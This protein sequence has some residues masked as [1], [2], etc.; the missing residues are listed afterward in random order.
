MPTWITRFRATVA[1]L[2][3]LLTAIVFLN[4]L[5]E[6]NTDIKPEVYIAPGD[7]LGRYISAWQSS[8]YLGSPNFNVG[9]V[10]VLLVV[11][12]LRGIGLSPEWA[13]KVFHLGLWLLAAVGAARLLRH[14]AP[15]AGRWGGLAAG[16]LYLANPYTIQAGATLAIALPMALLPWQVLCL[17]RALQAPRSWR[18]PAAFG[19]TFF[20]MSGM[21]VAVVPLLQL[22]A[23]VPVVIAARV[24]AGLAW[25]DALRVVA[26]CALFVVGV[27]LYWLVPAVSARATGAQIVEASETLS[28]IA[29]VS[30]YPEVLRGVGLWPLYGQGGDET[31]WVPQ[32][33]VYV[34]SP[35][36]IALTILW[37]VLA[38]LSLRFARGPVRAALVGSI[39]LAAVIMVGL[40]PSESSPASPFGAL[41]RGLLQ[42]PAL[43]AFRTTNKIGAVLV[44]AF[45]LALGL[46]V[47]RV[48]PWLWRRPGAPP[49]VA[50]VLA[51]VLGAWTLPAIGGRLYISPMNIPSYWKEAARAADQG[52]PSSTT[53]LLPGQVRP[54]YRWTVERPDDLTNSLMRRDA[55]LPDTTPNASPPGVNF[56]SALDATVQ[57]GQ[58]PEATVSTFARYLGSDKVL[59][60]HDTAWEDDGGARPAVTSRL[61]A[62]DPGLFGAGNFGRLGQFMMPPDGSGPSY[63]ETALPPVQLYDV[64]DARTAARVVPTAGQLVV[65]G[66]GFAFPSMTE[67][68]LL[69]DTPAVRYAQDVSAQQLARSLPTTGRMVITDTNARRDAIPNRLTAGQGP[70]LPASEEL[71]QSRTLGT[72][73]SDQTVLAA[74]GARVTASSSGAA[75]FD[76][77]YGIPEL[78]VDGDPDTGWR[79]GDF[80][81]GVGQTLTV[82]F[83]EPVRLDTV[84]V[85]QLDLGGVSIDRVTLTAG[86]RSAS[87]RLPEAGK[88]A[89]LDLG[90]VRADR[91]TLRIDSLRGEGYSLVG[92]A[93]LGL[94]GPKPVRAAR[95]PTTFSERY[96]ALDARGKQQFGRTPLDVLLRRVANEPQPNDDSEAGLRRVVALPDARTYRTSADVR[97]DGPL[98][99][100]YDR[101]AGLD[102]SI[103]VQSSGFFFDNPD[104]RASQAA[105]GDNGT[106]WVPGNALRGGWWEI[107]GPQR[108]IDQVTINQVPLP[109]RSND[110]TQFAGRVRISVDGRAVQ[111]ATLRPGRSSVPLPEGTRGRTVRV[112]V[113]GVD[114]PSDG[115]PARFTEIDT[116]LRTRAASAADR[117]ADTRCQTVATV[118]GQP[119][120]MRPGRDTQL[121][122]TGQPGTA[123]IG[124][125]ELD[126]DPGTHR[127]D[128]VDG[129]VLDNLDL[130]DTVEGTAPADPPQVSITRDR[131]SVKTLEVAEGDGPYYVL[132]GT[133]IDPRWS[134]TLEDGTDLGPPVLVDGFS[135]GWLVPDGGAHTITLR[136]DP[137]RWSTVALVVSGA[138]VVLATLLTLM[139]WPRRRRSAAP[140][141][142]DATDTDTDAADATDVATGATA[143]SGPTGQTG[144]TGAT[145]ASAVDAPTG[146]DEG[147]EADSADESRGTSL[148]GRLAWRAWPRVAKEALL[149]LLATFAVGVPGLVAGLA[150]VLLLRRSVR[151]TRLLYAG[152]GLVLASIVVYLAGLGDALGKVSADAVASSMWPHYLAGGGLVLALVGALRLD[153]EP[154]A[155]DRDEAPDGAE[156]GD[157]VRPERHDQTDQTDQTDPSGTDPADVPQTRSADA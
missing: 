125:G 130:R 107:S 35:M 109:E 22:L 76:L 34:A 11:G 75:F 102:P 80:Q 17:V 104:V 40:F 90:G 105:D 23:I 79:F 48:L 152:A 3:L 65:A 51:V 72:D 8:P 88:S 15:R 24:R 100:M 36:I 39:A 96:A 108:D 124:C 19:L 114:G 84:P 73:P 145:A 99:P 21:N 139:V 115:T 16:V 20:L 97:V 134:A 54:D 98:E 143:A 153:R 56:L 149:V 133:S 135:A 27:S 103:R 118:D 46:A 57:S 142:D 69:R 89:E 112:T 85:S 94:P 83:P 52:N 120:R 113:L 157:G 144:P 74:S 106:A 132:A 9:L 66:D 123:W 47:V 12:A 13:F 87:A 58:A 50:V 32:H 53:L 31:A 141:R 138:V 136:Y 154:A 127:I 45:A 4:G 128:P 121:V 43:A 77:P 25:R 86:G 60:R 1:G 116:G 71:T 95:T 92:I 155:R 111:D 70:L 151:P 42:Q 78:A 55:V 68:G 5:G 64:R 126:L 10:P 150:A 93:E 26:R 140:G 146:A 37:P 148:L 119:L 6:F 156:P 81:R 18:W 30:S 129:F 63:G 29:M 62:E 101:V 44:L 82:Q 38:L 14:V 49:V 91:V 137:Q 61:L 122:G 117:R 147:D 2:V 33:A 28:G 131:P 41:L 7:M 59:L 110:N 67:A